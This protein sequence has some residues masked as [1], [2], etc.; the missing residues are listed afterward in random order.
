MAGQGRPPKPAAVRRNRHA[1]QLG[2]IISNPLHGWQH[3]PVPE[4]PDGLVAA[5][6]EAWA[7]WM[8]SWFAANWVPADLPG[9]RLVI[10]QYDAV[11][12]GGTK[13]NDMTALVRLMDTYGI[14]PAGQQ[15]RRWAPPSDE[16][17]PSDNRKAPVAELAD[18]PYAHL[19]VAK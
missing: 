5:S 14:T 12:R 7:T 8:G 17:K 4:A 13:A 16:A 3:G 1:P 11:Q 15:A 6:R 10:T 19:K 18:S 2:E 9:L